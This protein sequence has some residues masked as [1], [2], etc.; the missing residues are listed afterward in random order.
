M[1]LKA[2]H[3]YAEVEGLIES[4]ELSERPIHLVLR[5]RNDGS[6]EPGRGLASALD[7]AIRR[8]RK[9]SDR[10]GTAVQTA[11]L[12]RRQFGRQGVLSGRRYRQG[13]GY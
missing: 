12:P 13:F 10:S 3:A 7:D 5:L 11:G 8:K 1:L 6:V 9:N 2:L 4:I